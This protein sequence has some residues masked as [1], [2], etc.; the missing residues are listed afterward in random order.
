MIVGAAA[1]LLVTTPMSSLTNAVVAAQAGIS[2]R[3][4]YRH[5]PTREVL[6]AA[7]ACEVAARIAAPEVPGSIEALPGYVH[8][9]FARFEAHAGLVEAALHSDLFPSMRDGQAAR[10]WK[11]LRRLLREAFPTV[12]TATVDGAAANLRY[13]LSATTWRYYRQQF[14][15]DAA[16]TERCVAEAVTIILTALR[17]GA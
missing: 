9:L 7:L 2:E 5:F 1:D 4:V 13:L 3:T 16:R 15:F 17:T 10:R 6:F 8:A 12:P 14:A 11:A